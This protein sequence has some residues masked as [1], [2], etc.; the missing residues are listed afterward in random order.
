MSYQRSKSV[1][2]KARRHIFWTVLAVPLIVW[3]IPL[4]LEALGLS[5]DTITELAVLPLG[6]GLLLVGGGGT[7]FFRCP[8]CDKC[9]FVRW[10]F[11]TPCPEKRCSRCGNDLTVAHTDH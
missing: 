4:L 1:Y 7:F 11:S 9:V 10:I 2:D 6:L 3:I 8:K 5:S